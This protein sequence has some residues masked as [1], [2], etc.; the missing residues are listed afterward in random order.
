V[1]A[2]WTSLLAV[3]ALPGYQMKA[4]SGFNRYDGLIDVSKNAVSS[5][6]NLA[7]VTTDTKPKDD[8]VIEFK[9]S[10]ESLIDDFEQKVKAPPE[11]DLVVVWDLPNLNVRIGSLQPTYGSKWA[12]SR[13]QRGQTYIWSDDTSSTQIPVIALRNLVPELLVKLG[14]QAAK[15]HLQLLE[16]RDELALI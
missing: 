12:H 8:A 7:V 9:V 3:K 4:L 11:I 6:G 16:T 13:Q 5:E 14:D 10:F 15:P 2:L 1:I